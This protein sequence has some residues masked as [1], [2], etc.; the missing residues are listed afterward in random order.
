MAPPTHP[1]GIDYTQKIHHNT[2]LFLQPPSPPLANKGITVLITGASRGIGKATA[3]SYAR[4]GASHIAL[5]ARSNLQAV[6]TAVLQAAREAK[7][8]APQV[9]LLELNIASLASVNAALATIRS[10]F[11]RLD[12]LV[13][14]AGFLETFARLTDSNPDETWKS[15]EINYRGTVLM[16]RAF[17][18]LLI[19]SKGLGV[20][21][22]VS[23][24][25][26]LLPGEG[27]GTYSTT[28]FAL[29]R[30]TEMLDLE[31][32]KE[33]VL[34]MALHPGGVM[35]ELSMVLPE[36]LHEREFYLC[37]LG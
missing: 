13:N 35:T 1:M 33:G 28:K 14:N 20:L 22:N 23:S 5:A 15:W 36:V 6:Q 2:Y 10:S 3:L 18:P 11:G 30:F 29:L 26:A 32:G 17:V 27:L 37:F 34:A 12:I 9:L 21:I 16:S 25:G 24:I 8:P 4:A 19:E 7:C 31:Y